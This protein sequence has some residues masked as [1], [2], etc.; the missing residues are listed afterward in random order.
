[1]TPP[2][3]GPPPQS[4]PSANSEPDDRPGTGG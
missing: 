1:V 3:N 2:Q 4:Q